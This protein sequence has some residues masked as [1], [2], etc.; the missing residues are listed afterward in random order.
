[1]RILTAQHRRYPIR[2]TFRISRG[3]KTVADV[4][5]VEIRD[6]D[7]VGR[8]EC[9]PYARY[10]QSVDG[11]LDELRSLV[12]YIADATIE[13]LQIDLAPGPV[14]NAVECALWDLQ[15]RQG[16]ST[17]VSLLPDGA[18]LSLLQTA[19][20]LSLDTPAAMG[21]AAAAVAHLPLLKLKLGGDVDIDRVV[22]V[23]AA[24]PQARLIADAN[25]SWTP[26]LLP[27]VAP[28]LAELGV[29]LIEQP[30]PADQD[31]ALLTYASPVCFSADE[32][33]H[34]RRQLGELRAKYGAVTVKLDKTGGPTEAVALLEE[35]RSL[36][37][38][39]MVG[40]MVATSLSMAPGFIAAQRADLVHLDGPLLLADDV[41][42]GM[43]Y[44]GA[45]L[46]PPPA[47]LWKV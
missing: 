18:G 3:S 24:A 6:G 5:Q 7:H 42:P 14:R 40:C 16:G 19:Y 43:P 32:S 21:K 20:T 13:Q 25:E 1:M 34:D 4:V 41:D 23:R 36:G 28:A 27:R 29:E 44:S 37:L 39:T 17:C 10:G 33:C 30:L 12:T 8:G 31:D 45:E 2:S 38:K 35:A 46:S 11:V 47:D 15:A 9:V 22:A 26:E